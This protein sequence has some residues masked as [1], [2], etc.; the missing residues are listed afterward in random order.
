MEHQQHKCNT[1]NRAWVVA[2][3][4]FWNQSSTFDDVKC[5]YDQTSVL[6]NTDHLVYSTRPA[7]GYA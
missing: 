4:E 3:T 5:S 7:S 1:Q 6:Y 2:E